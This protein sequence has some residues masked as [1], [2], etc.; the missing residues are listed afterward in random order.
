[1]LKTGK[2]FK[3]QLKFFRSR[4]FFR[5]LLLQLKSK[6]IQT[7]QKGLLLGPL[8]LILKLGDSISA[9]P[10]VANFRH[11]CQQKLKCWNVQNLAVDLKSALSIYYL[12]GVFRREYSIRA[13]TIA[14]ISQLA[15][16]WQL[17]DNALIVINWQIQTHY[18][19]WMIIA[20]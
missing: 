2:N 1:M 5:P 7:L 17:Q 3:K 6:V 12:Q 15:K 19:C 18:G 11:F 16:Y 9:V 13:V 4:S 20:E 14:I 10:T 8:Y